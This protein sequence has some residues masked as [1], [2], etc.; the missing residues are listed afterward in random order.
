MNQ[1]APLYG[2]VF[3]AA[4]LAIGYGLQASDGSLQNG[5]IVAVTIGV[6]LAILGLVRPFAALG[7]RFDERLPIVVI[8]G[9]LGLQFG[10]LLGGP[11]GVDMRIDL[12]EYATYQMGVG[13]AAVLSGLLFTS[14]KW[15]QRVVFPALLVLFMLLGVWMLKASPDPAIDVT[16]FHR[17]AFAALERGQNPHTQ[18]IANV[19]G[20]DGFYGAEV[21]TSDGRVNVGYP[22]LPLSLYLTFAA[23]K[24][25]GDYRTS[26]LL[27]MVIGAAALGYARATKWSFGAA[28]VFLFTPRAFFVLEQ[29]WTDSLAAM[30][31]GLTIFLACRAPRWLWVGVGLLFAIKQYAIG[32]S[33]LLFLLWTDTPWVKVLRELARAAGLAVV[34]TLPVFIWNPSA[35]IKD[36]ILFQIRQPFRIDSLSYLANRS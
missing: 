24:A 31:V 15:T 23:H 36:V 19:Y 9:G 17:Q 26:L 8:A 18:S 33:P 34:L 10:L 27:A 2:S 20:S 14:L 30:F 1:S 22:Y 32:L 25:T 16:A 28:A 5:A 13:V 21:L 7:N 29:G 4:M 35:F 11:P 3:V 6:M 12:N